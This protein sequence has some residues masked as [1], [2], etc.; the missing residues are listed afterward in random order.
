MAR[1]VQDIM[2]RELLS[3]RPDMVAREVGDILRS[4]KVGAAPVLDENRRPL[5]V[6]SLRD[7]LDTDRVVR[8]VMSRP[9]LCVASSA[10]IEDAARQLAR[11]DMHHLLVVDAAGAAVGMVSTLDLL[12]AVLDMPTRH[13]SEFPHWDATTRSSWTDDCLLDGES[14]L[15]TPQGP[16]VIALLTSHPGEPDTILWVETTHDVRSRILEL[17]E[18]PSA[19]APALAILLARH[20]LRFRATI[21]PDEA[22][23]TH[24]AALLSERVERMPPP[25]GT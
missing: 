2:N 6:V 8:D 24:I 25:G 19:H 13:P 21:V 22:T 10:R 14:A 9:A 20:G 1:T 4:F 15:Q 3:V 16:G 12:R 18:L 7:A 23:R 5:G 17:A 11:T